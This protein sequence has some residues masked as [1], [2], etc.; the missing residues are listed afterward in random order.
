MQTNLLRKEA[1]RSKDRY[2]YNLTINGVYRPLYGFD[3]EFDACYQSVK[4]A[5]DVD[6]ER[7]WVIYLM[8]KQTLNVDGCFFECGVFRGGSASLIAQV[9]D[10]RKP[11]HL[12]DTFA[13]MPECDA[14]RDDHIAG[15]FSDVS[16]ESVRRVVGHSQ[17]VEFHQ[18][19]IP[20]TFSGMEEA[21]I[22]FAHVDVDI[23]SSMKACCEFIYPRMTAGGVIVFDDYGQFTCRGARD[24]IDEYFDG[25]RS[26]PLPLLTKQAV[27]FK[28]K[29]D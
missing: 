24:A 25:K 12:F 26:I 27:V 23:Y 1:Q 10:D 21:K 6:I 11:L 5:T 16:V 28:I 7:L 2:Y 19:W 9:A 3:T 22:A 17:S 15:D 4:G 8:A 29:G 14:S 20:D 13:G 18:G